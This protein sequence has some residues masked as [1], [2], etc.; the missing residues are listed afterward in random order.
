MNESISELLYQSFSKPLWSL[1][2]LLFVAYVKGI[3]KNIGSTVRLFAG[4][5]LIYRGTVNS[6]DVGIDLGRLGQC[7]VGSGMESKAVSFTTAR[8]E[9]AL[10]YSVLD[11]VIRK[12]AVVISGSNLAQ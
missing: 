10:N 9:D 1:G 2:P 6:D 11:Q 7:A 3:C 4:G 8:V 12:R 5:C